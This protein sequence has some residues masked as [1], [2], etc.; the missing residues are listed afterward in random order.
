[1]YRCESDHKEGSKQNNWRFSMWCR[2][3]FVRVSWTARKSY[4]STLKKI[5][6]QYSLEDWCW[7]HNTLVTWCKAV[8]QWKR[9]WCWERLKAKAEGATEDEVTGWI[10]YW[11]I[12]DLI[13]WT[14]VWIKSRRHEGH[15]SLACCN[16][17]GHRVRHN[18]VIKQWQIPYMWN[19]KMELMNLSLK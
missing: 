17:W 10:N 14:W 12:S 13:K 2:R 9:P 6:P 1:M 8:T 11:L 15:G 4:Q 3:R 19:Q 18:L 5:N 16:P 7:S